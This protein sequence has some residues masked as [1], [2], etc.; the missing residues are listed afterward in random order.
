M[1][2]ATPVSVDDDNSADSLKRFAIH[3][4]LE[5][6]EISIGADLPK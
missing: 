2:G 3:Q 1:D 5:S 6:S 4:C